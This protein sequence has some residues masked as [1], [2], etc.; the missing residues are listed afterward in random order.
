M[1]QFE[2]FVQKFPDKGTSE[3]ITLSSLR[4]QHYVGKMSEK[5]VRA[6]SIHPLVDQI[7][8]AEGGVE[9]DPDP[10]DNHSNLKRKD[11]RYRPPFDVEYQ[12][13]CVMIR[14]L[15]MISRHQPEKLREIEVS[16]LLVDAHVYDRSAGSDTWIHVFDVGIRW[17][18]QPYKE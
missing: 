2:A 8:H 14:P 1:V 9:R 4:Y 13:E 12:D 10:A 7:L 15:L 6:I 5:E 3:C 16:G 18:R 11:R 17:P